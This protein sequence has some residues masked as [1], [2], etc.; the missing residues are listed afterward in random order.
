MPR[1]LEKVWQSQGRVPRPKTT[2]KKFLVSQ[3]R[4][5]PAFLLHSITAWVPPAGGVVALQT[6]RE[7]KVLPLGRGGRFHN[8]SPRTSALVFGL[9]PAGDGEG[10]V[11]G[12]RHFPL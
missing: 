1:S 6:A 9:K 5:G 4:M 8:L 7:F 12:R 11:G 2:V 10:G 3:E